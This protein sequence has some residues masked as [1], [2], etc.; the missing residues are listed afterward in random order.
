MTLTSLLPTLRA[1]LP[2]PFDAT[3]WP[4][5][6]LPLIDDVTV[7][8][9]S[10]RRYAE[11]CG[12]PCVCTGPAIV[13]LSGGSVSATESTT[14]MMMSVV[15]VSGTE[16][17]VDAC[18]DELDGVAWQEVRLLGRVSHAHDARFALVDADSDAATATVVLPRD[19]RPGDTI[20]LPCAGAHTV[21]EVRPATTAR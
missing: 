3:R 5:G 19:V 11:L 7:A 16:V 9:V 12:T 8:A 13:P 2:S 14:V 18:L 10:L 6:S 17:R 4:A 1:S 20:A 15:A 21:G